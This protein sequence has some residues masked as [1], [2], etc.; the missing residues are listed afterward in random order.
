M[1]ATNSPGTP[2][3]L[4]GGLLI[5]LCIAIAL[6]GVTLVQTYIYSL[7]S[8][9]DPIWMKS[10]VGA[11]CLLETAHFISVMRLLYFTTIIIPDPKNLALR[12]SIDWYVC[13][14]SHEP[15][16]MQLN[17]SPQRSIP[18]GLICQALIIGLVQG[19]YVLRLWLLS[20][21]F[22]ILV[23]GTP[24]V[25][26]FRVVSLIVVAGESIR[27]PA[28][29][30]FIRQH[31]PSIKITMAAAIVANSVIAI[32]FAY[33]TRQGVPIATTRQRHTDNSQTPMTYLLHSGA[34]AALISI[35]AI[36]TFLRM[37]NTLVF[38][39][40]I[41]IENHLYANSLLG[42]LDSRPSAQPRRHLDGTTIEFSSAFFTLSDLSTTSSGIQSI[43]SM[44]KHNSTLR[45][46]D[47][48]SFTAR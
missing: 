14:Q 2:S 3:E 48:L 29:M 41:A 1:D 21:R 8:G 6:Y 18:L 15:C 24:A 40:L 34:L 28:W 12:E 5:A 37:E 45:A 30:A 42:L 17:M 47:R 7:K 23:F 27:T 9:K 11:V 33:Y 35:I 20:K 32:S 22:K 31:E 13:T 36:C 39:G 26:L 44:P 19:F 38:V 16:L 4:F 43:G 46:K 25:V 10:L